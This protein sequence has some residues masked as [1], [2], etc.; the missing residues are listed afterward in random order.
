MINWILGLINKRQ[1]E[2]H[3]QNLM[4][5]KA[6]AAA[7]ISRDS[8]AKASIGALRVARRTHTLNRNGHVF[9]RDEL[10]CAEHELEQAEQYQFVGLSKM[11]NH[12]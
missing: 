12:S 2:L 6:L 5:K 4:L 8:F 11:E 9:T 1:R 3:S 7:V 10:A